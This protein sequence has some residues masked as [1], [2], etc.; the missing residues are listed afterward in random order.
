MDHFV[1][2]V[3]YPNN[4]IE[5]LV[6]AHGRC[7]NAKR[8]HLAAADHVA[9]WVERGDVRQ[10][11]LEMIAQRKS[12]ESYPQRSRS[13]ARS[14]YLRLPEDV[15]LWRMAREFVPLDRERLVSVFRP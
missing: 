10:A 15:R 12:W 14:I 9:R 4:A 1:P 11:D 8:D 2:W 7:N 3:R 6:L 13:V 5:N